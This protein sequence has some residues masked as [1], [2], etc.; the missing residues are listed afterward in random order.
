MSAPDY[1]IYYWAG[2]GVVAVKYGIQIRRISIGTDGVDGEAAL[3]PIGK[4]CNLNVG[5]DFYRAIEVENYVTALLAGSAASFIRVQDQRC[6]LKRSYGDAGLELKFLHEVWQCIQREPDRAAAIIFG[7]LGAYD[8]GDVEATTQR[9]WH[10]AVRVLR[11]E[12]HYDQL[13]AL[14]KRLM[15]AKQMAGEEVRRLLKGE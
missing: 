3:E 2:I 13:R 11:Q 4:F 14:S 1:H 7:S 10:R 9:L 8:D 15:E 5:Q 12:L 6:N